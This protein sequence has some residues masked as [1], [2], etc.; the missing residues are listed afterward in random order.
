MPETGAIERARPVAAPQPAGMPTLR[1]SPRRVLPYLVGGAM[2]AV[3]IWVLRSTL[4]RYDLADLQ[5]ELAN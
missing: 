3:A 2:F 5:A 1:D 4:R